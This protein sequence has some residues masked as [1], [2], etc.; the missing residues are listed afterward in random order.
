MQYLLLTIL[1]STSIALM[2]KHN[3]SRKGNEIVLLAGN[4]F[5]AA[6]I[7]GIMILLNPDCVFSIY[8]LIFGFVLGS[9]FVVSFF[10]FAKAVNSAGT[11][12]ATV[13]SRLSVVIPLFLSIIVYSETPGLYQYIGISFTLLTIFLFYKSLKS[14]KGKKLRSTDYI[15][16]ILVLIGIGINDFCMKV[17]SEWRPQNEEPWFI[18]SIFLSAFIYSSAYLLF[19]RIKFEKKTAFRGAFLGVPNVFSSVFLLF[20]LAVVPAFI[21]YP[22]VNIGIILL[23]SILALIIWKEKLNKFGIAALIT[24]SS[25]IILLGL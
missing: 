24:G 20:A 25:A 17:F 1:C 22:A 5:I 7:S 11:A 2:L 6:L 19:R 3:N 14:V 18:L 12:L 9:C 15:Y 10:V 8:S 16:L 21:V 13:S 23:T 4:Y